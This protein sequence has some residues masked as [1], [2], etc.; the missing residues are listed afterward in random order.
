M[1]TRPTG[2]SEG[3]PRLALRDDPER[4]PISYFVARLHCV[5][6]PYVGR[7]IA[8]AKLIMQAHHGAMKSDE[9]RGEVAAA[10]EQGRDFRISMNK[11]NGWNDVSN[12]RWQDRDS[13]NALADNFC[14]K[15]R[16]LKNRL[17]KVVPS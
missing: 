3:R 16:R 8:L 15:V 7:P 1:V 13:A 2:R 14:R 9:E 5:S 4:Y 10:L 17:D 11:R 12:A 6:P